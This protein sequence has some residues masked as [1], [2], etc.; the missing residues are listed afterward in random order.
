MKAKIA[1]TIETEMLAKIDKMAEELNLNRSQFIE[2]VLSVGL[3]DALLLKTLGFID[4][5]KLVM[6]VKDKVSKRIT[7][8]R[9]RDAE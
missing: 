2:N 4:V 1:I 6:R 8:R 9:T 5:A 7:K 3:A